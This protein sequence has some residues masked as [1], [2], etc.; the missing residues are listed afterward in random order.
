MTNHLSNEQ[1]IQRIV[2]NAGPDEIQ[3]LAE[4]AQCETE[5]V[6]MQ[7]ALSDFRGSLRNWADQNPGSHPR[8]AFLV[9]RMS[10][11]SPG[12]ILRWSLVSAALA[13]AAVVPIYRES[14]ERERAARAA[15]DALLLE[16]VNAQLSRFM[17]AS[18]EPLVELIPADD[19]ADKGER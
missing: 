10:T 8:Q 1:L 17:P 5:L 16:Q 19:S 18:I 11:A 14:R 2:G 13:A 15:E 12:R 9:H 6:E 7:H 4:C 3:H